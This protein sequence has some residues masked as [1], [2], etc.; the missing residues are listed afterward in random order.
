MATG[1]IATSLP[2]YV[3]ESTFRQ[4]TTGRTEDQREAA[5]NKDAVAHFLH[6]CCHDFSIFDPHMLVLTNIIIGG[7]RF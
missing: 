2:P 4:A 3:R 6:K 7:I 1:R 5:E